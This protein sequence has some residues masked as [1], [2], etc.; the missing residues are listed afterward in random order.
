MW[1][2]LKERHVTFIGISIASVILGS[3]EIDQVETR[4]RIK[5]KNSIEFSMCVCRDKT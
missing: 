1:R 2:I 3:I 4:T 5:T